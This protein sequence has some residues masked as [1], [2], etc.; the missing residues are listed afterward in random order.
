MAKGLVH[1]RICKKSIDR[2][3]EKENIDWVMPSKNYFYHFRCYCDWKRKKDNIHSEIDDDMWLDALWDYLKKDLKMPVDFKKM[4]SQW[5]NFLKKG[6]TAKGIYFTIKYFYDI[7]KG[8]VKKSE[9]GIGIVPYIYSDSCSYWVE[10]EEKDAG[11]CQRIEKQIQERRAQK[12]IIVYQKEKAK[13]KKGIYDLAS[14]ADMPED[15]E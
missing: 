14:I 7:K 1:C 4:K 8:D 13:T 6:L 10:R 3:K 2:V 9:N 15:D 12:T 5:D 11:I